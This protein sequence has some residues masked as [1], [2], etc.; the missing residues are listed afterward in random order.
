MGDW[1]ERPV[2]FDAFE[3]QTAPLRLMRGGA[4]IQIS[5]QP[6]RLLA[7]LVSRP[8]ELVTHD[9]II[10]ALW[11]Q[12]TVNYERSI[13]VCV[14]Q[15]RKALQDEADS[16][17][18]V[19]TVPKQG[20]CFIAPVSKIEQQQDPRT[21]RWGAR[22]YQVAATLLIVAGVSLTLVATRPLGDTNHESVASDSYE[23]GLFM[24]RQNDRSSVERSLTYFL[25]AIRN[26]P[27][28]AD[29]HGRASEAYWI[30]GDPEAARGRA[31]LALEIERD[32]P[33]ALA[34]IGQIQLH[35]DH[36]WA[37]AERSFR[38]AIA[39]RGQESS[40]YQGLATISLLRGDGK[41]AIAFMHKARDLDPASALLQGDLGW[42]YYFAR[43][44]RQA[45]SAC[46]DAL[47]LQPTSRAPQICILR[48]AAALGD[49][50][51]LHNQIAILMTQEGATPD[52]IKLMNTTAPESALQW[53]DRWR[54]AQL[55]ANGDYEDAFALLAFAAANAG[56]LEAAIDYVE[57]A[58][59]K[60]DPMALFFLV[61][62]SFDELQSS[63]RFQESMS[64]LRN[65]S[66]TQRF[67]SPEKQ[68]SAK[69]T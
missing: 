53:Y 20:Y 58:I 64:K 44:D 2:A 50:G 19:R 10:Q 43:N 61:D 60:R 46:A 55:T 32:N 62:R 22:L 27:N 35:H 49:Y 14:R 51:K 8:G 42:F 37:A 23:L 13:H 41:R 15:V 6:L 7:L 26:D 69:R 21:F 1:S 30:L 24:L 39:A 16:P 12:R 40:P 3:L 38:A 65:S 47:N 54:F 9:E 28:F 4:E 63:R 52:E 48:A 34:S 18:F 59:E 36:D 5:L 25:D 17:R 33:V 57:R 31:Q 11:P 56:E 68:P 45:L 67:G 29:A 66:M